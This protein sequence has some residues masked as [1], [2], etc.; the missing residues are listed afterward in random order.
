MDWVDAKG[1]AHSYFYTDHNLLA[2]ATGIANITQS[3]L[4]LAGI[5]EG[6]NRLQ[7][8]FNLQPGDIWSTPGNFFPILSANETVVAAGVFNTFPSYENGG[9]FFHTLGLE[10]VARGVVGQSE[11][12]WTAFRRFMDKG[13]SFF[14]CACCYTLSA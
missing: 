11:Q 14:V 2:V 1:F 9:S 13:Y 10:L 3:K 8:N 7:K 4:I 12:V 6:Y 5:D